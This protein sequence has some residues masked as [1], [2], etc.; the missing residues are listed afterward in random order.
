M[1]VAEILKCT[2]CKNQIHE[3]NR[4]ENGKCRHCYN[5]LK[6]GVSDINNCFQ[7]SV[8]VID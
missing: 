7:G 2:I 1:G 4:S 6:Y 8:I 3:K 5:K